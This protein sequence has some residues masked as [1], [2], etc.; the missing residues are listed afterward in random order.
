MLYYDGANEFLKSQHKSFSIPRFHQCSQIISVSKHIILI[1]IWIFSCILNIIIEVLFVFIIQS[2]DYLYL[3]H[4]IWSWFIL[5][6]HLGNGTKQK[7]ASY[8][9]RFG[10]FWPAFFS[11]GWCENR[12][13]E[14]SMLEAK[15]D[16]TVVLSSLY[17]LYFNVTRLGLLLLVAP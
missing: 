3:D 2:I 13:E 17:F 8:E 9:Y 4:S 11:L 14:N 16:E 5:F 7:Y 1:S 6:T 10:A 12:Q 15:E